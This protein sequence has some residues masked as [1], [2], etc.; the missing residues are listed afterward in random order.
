MFRILW[1]C[2]AVLLLAVAPVA[3]QDRSDGYGH[4]AGISAFDLEELNDLYAEMDDDSFVDTQVHLAL[5]SGAISRS[6][7]PD[8]V[9][10]LL[11]I[12]ELSWKIHDK[13]LQALSWTERAELAEHPSLLPKTHYLFGSI[14]DTSP[15]VDGCDYDG[16]TGFDRSM[17]ESAGYKFQGHFALYFRVDADAD[18][19]R[20]YCSRSTW[21]SDCGN[22]AIP[23]WSLL[24][25]DSGCPSYSWHGKRV[26]DVV[27]LVPTRW[28]YFYWWAPKHEKAG[29]FW[30]KW[31]PHF[32]SGCCDPG[33]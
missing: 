3:G 15:V 26:K 25:K 18:C 6:K 30:M 1:G 32:S 29:W 27:M 9:L 24:C 17:T 4:V 12:S 11:E 31:G 28:W 10:Y 8:F 14:G 23:R 22:G 33:C 19:Y 21:G 13:S 5:E 7:Q 16:V 20:K 2:L